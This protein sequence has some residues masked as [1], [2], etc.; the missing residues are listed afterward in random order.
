V[1]GGLALGKTLALNDQ[2]P[3]RLCIGTQGSDLGALS[4]LVSTQRTYSTA[5]ISLWAV[6]GVLLTSGVVLLAVDV[7]RQRAGHRLFSWSLTP[8][9]DVA[10]SGVSSRLLLG[11]RF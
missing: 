8:H 1:L 6:G 2:C 4:D 10:A 9:L 7:H 11:G 3:D 5:A